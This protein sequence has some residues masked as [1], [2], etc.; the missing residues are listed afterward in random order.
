MQPHNGNIEA[1]FCRIV[2]SVSS[3]KYQ[4]NY[5]RLIINQIETKLHLLESPILSTN[6]RQ[7]QKRK[8]ILGIFKQCYIRSPLAN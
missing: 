3:I 6:G 4:I 5:I 2:I 8:V 1:I 7:P